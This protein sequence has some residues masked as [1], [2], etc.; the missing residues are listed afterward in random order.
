MSVMGTLRTKPGNAQTLPASSILSEWERTRISNIAGNSTPALERST[1]LL[2]LNR[3]NRGLES[4]IGGGVMESYLITTWNRIYRMNLSLFTLGFFLGVAVMF[5]GG[6]S[7]TRD[8][9]CVRHSDGKLI[10][11][12]SADSPSGTL[13]EGDR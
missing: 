6:C 13:P 8:K 4:T 12:M 2:A 9:I 11:E 1:D 10:I 5:F 7:P 3:Q